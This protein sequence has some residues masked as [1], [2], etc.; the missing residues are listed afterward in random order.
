MVC[1]R[2]CLLKEW[3]EEETE[4][5]ALALSQPASNGVASIATDPSVQR[6]SGRLPR[7]VTEQQ[8][9]EQQRTALASVSWSQQETGAP[10]QMATAPTCLVL[11]MLTAGPTRPLF[12]HRNGQQRLPACPLSFFFCSNGWQTGAAAS[13]RSTQ[14]RPAPTLMEQQLIRP[15]TTHRQSAICKFLELT[16][17]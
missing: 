15:C 10:A 11:R 12:S 2:V 8:R 6:S 16:Y 4:E 13:S 3:G 14:S 5:E 7:K 9:T 17:R 1:F